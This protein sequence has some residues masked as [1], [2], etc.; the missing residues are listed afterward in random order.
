ML[1]SYAEI[2][3]GKKTDNFDELMAAATEERDV[4]DGEE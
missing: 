2:L 4:A 1:T 3:L